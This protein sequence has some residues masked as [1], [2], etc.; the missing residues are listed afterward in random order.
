VLG[1]ANGQRNLLLKLIELADMAIVM[2]K[3]MES[4]ESE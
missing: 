3:Q 4:M 2:N 1:L